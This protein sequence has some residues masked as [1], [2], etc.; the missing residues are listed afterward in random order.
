MPCGNASGSPLSTEYAFEL[1]SLVDRVVVVDEI[2][3]VDVVNDND[4]AVDGG[5]VVV[6]AGAV[7][8]PFSGLLEHQNKTKIKAKMKKT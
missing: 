4:N 1:E 3:E 8:V 2:D 6:G 7:S 5:C